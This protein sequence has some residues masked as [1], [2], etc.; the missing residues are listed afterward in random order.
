MSLPKV[1]YQ[2]LGRIRYQTA[3][4]YQFETIK[5]VIDTKREVRE[6]TPSVSAPFW[7]EKNSFSP[8]DDGFEDA[9]LL[10]Y[11]WDKAGGLVTIQI[12]DSNGHA[13]KSLSVNELLGTE[14]VLRWQGERNDGTKATVGIYI[15]S[16]TTLFPNG[17]TMHQKLPC[18]LTTLF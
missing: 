4:D 8:D 9:L 16:I 3:W 15:L 1:I 18:G 12:F 13:V 17:S 6:S 14:G 11:K 10:H 5:K 2:D 7:L